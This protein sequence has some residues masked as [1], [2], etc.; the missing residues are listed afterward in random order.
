MG[1][2]EHA[3]QDGRKKVYCSIVT[4]EQKQTQD[5]EYADR[6]REVGRREGSAERWG[7]GYSGASKNKQT[8]D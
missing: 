2:P 8:F 5:T 6:H 1:G 3:T 4:K 7:K